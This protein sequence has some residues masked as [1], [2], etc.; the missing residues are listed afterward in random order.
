MLFWKLP[1]SGG[2]A[3]SDVGESLTQIKAPGPRARDASI[4]MS[5]I[6]FKTPPRAPNGSTSEQTIRNLDERA[7]RYTSYP[8]ADRFMEA[9]GPSAHQAWLEKRSKDQRSPLSVYVHLPFCESLCY[10]CACNKIVTRDHGKAAV[11][12][13]YLEREI[14]LQLQH[15]GSGHK[16]SQ[17]HWGGGSPTFL[18]PEEMAHLM[19]ILRARFE[20]VEGGDYSIEVDPR[21]TALETVHHLAALGFNRMSI[22]V[23]DFDAEVQKAVHRIQP[24]AMTLDVLGAAREAG[25][26]SVNFDLIHGLP[27]QT[28]EG[29]ARTLDIVTAARPQRIALYSYAHLP[30]R[31]KAQRRIHTIE[32]PSGSEKLAIL[33]LARERLVGA[34]YVYIGIDHFALPGDALAVAQRSGRLHRN[35]QG[36]TTQP[37]CDLLG[38]GVSAISKIGPTY[39]QNHR[40]LAEYYDALD[41]GCLPIMRGVELGADDVLR[42]NIIMSLMCQGQVSID[43]VNAAHLINFDTTF[44]TEL[45]AL[46]PYE[47][48]GLVTITDQWLSVTEKGRYY[49]RAISAVFDRHLRAAQAREHYSKVL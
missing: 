27:R 44:A 37:E 34:G 19:R 1:L 24:L 22:G 40:T 5:V 4:A 36:Y 41:Q 11:Y 20:L 21:S 13:R 49:L 26:T 46:A 2:Y 28:L 39:S 23:Q 12:L 42:R 33:E 43:A 16:V 8:T 3:D 14:N 17:L 47:Q 45:A 35:F 30:A 25:F 10:Y 31:F 18:R 32:L 6:T 48:A 29:F 15:L 38:L 7:P 9:F